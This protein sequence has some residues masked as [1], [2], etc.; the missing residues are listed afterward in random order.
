MAA[1]LRS[2]ASKATKAE[3]GATAEVGRGIA[4]AKGGGGT[5]KAGGGAAAKAKGGGGAANAGAKRPAGTEAETPEAKRSA[6]SEASPHTERVAALAAAALAGD[7]SAAEAIMG[8]ASPLAPSTPASAEMQVQV[9]SLREQLE[10]KST[11]LDLAELRIQ[12][13]TLELGK[14]KGE[15]SV[16]TVDKQQLGQLQGEL[17]VSRCLAG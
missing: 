5:T 10:E 7:R 16:A 8:G 3:A 9:S 15:L 2:R 11:K 12:E 1:S 14:V 6:A 13:V 17:T 4:K